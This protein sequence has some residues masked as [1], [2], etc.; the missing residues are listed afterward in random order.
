MSN[1]I[2][3]NGKT[4]LGYYKKAIENL[5]RTH[6]E[7]QEELYNLKTNYSPTLESNIQSYQTEIN[8]LKSELKITQERLLITEESAIEAINIADNFQSELQNLKELM[9]AIQLSR[10]SKIFEELAQI[11]EQLIY[12]QAQIQQPK[13]EEHLQSKILQALSNLQSQYSNLEAELTLISLASGWDY[14]KLKELLVGNKWNEADLETYN[15][16]LKVS[17]REGECWLDDGNIRQFP[18][19]DLRIINNLWLKYSNGKFG[20]SIQK[21]IW[22]DANE[23]YKRFGDRVGWLFNL[24]NNEW[25]KYE[26]YIFSLSAPEGHLPSTVRIVGLGYRSVEELPHRLKIFLSKY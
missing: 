20:F 24:V 22:Q 13:F 3:S 4:P 6:K 5:R 16:I 1:T 19:H 2:D 11:K 18:R 14:T 25:T 10:N 21:R 7:L 12:L 8:K 15:A 17:E 26:D 23:D 9:S